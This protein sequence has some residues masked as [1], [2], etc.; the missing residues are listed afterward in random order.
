MLKDLIHS[1]RLG[2]EAHVLRA[3][4]AV[5]RTIE[6]LV[7]GGVGSAEELGRCGGVAET[8]QEVVQ[9]D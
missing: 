5:S 4:P 6:V 1:P 7:V 2:P 8:L 9:H 3:R